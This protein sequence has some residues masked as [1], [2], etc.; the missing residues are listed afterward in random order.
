MEEVMNAVRREA[1]RT[2]ARTAQPRMAIVSSY[3]PETYSVKVKLMPEGIETG[4]APLASQQV[5]NGWGLFS[6]PSI[7]DQVVVVFQEGSGG[8]PVVIGS[9][10]NDEDRPV[11]GDIQGTPDGEARIVNQSGARIR[12]LKNG[13]IEIR[14]KAGTQ[15]LL[16]PDGSVDINA[17]V[18]RAGALGA[19]FRKLVMDNFMA[20]YN[21]HTHPANNTPPNSGLMT[22]AHLTTNLTGA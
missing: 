15:V 18:V 13:Q 12:L 2:H 5:G 16:N 11:V 21:S 6:P 20:T 4:W 7:G 9:I 14:Q 10:Y 22:T 19:L 1:A 17:P 3:N 8:S